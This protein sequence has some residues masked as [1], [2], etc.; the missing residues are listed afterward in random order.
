VY[1]Q[2]IHVLKELWQSKDPRH[3][4]SMVWGVHFG[5]LEKTEF[6]A[7][8][9]IFLSS[10]FFHFFP[11]SKSKYMCAIKSS[12]PIWQSLISFEQY[13]NIFKLLISIAIVRDFKLF[14]WMNEQISKQPLIETP[15]YSDN[16]KNST[17]NYVKQ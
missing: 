4:V 17:P 1:A 16:I 8:P 6:N 5:T 11:S 3:Y 14:L 7:T 13:F 12:Q 9:Y 2:N 15:Y 10:Q